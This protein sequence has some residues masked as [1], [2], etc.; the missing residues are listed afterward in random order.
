MAGITRLVRLAVSV[1]EI[2]GKPV[3]GAW[4][5]RKGDGHKVLDVRKL[6]VLVLVGG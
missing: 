6:A 3:G 2:S 1:G 5:Q 4:W